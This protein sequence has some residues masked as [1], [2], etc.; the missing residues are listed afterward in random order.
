MHAGGEIARAYEQRRG[1]KWSGIW[2]LD[3]GLHEWVQ[4]GGGTY[5]YEQ[6]EAQ[7]RGGAKPP[8][9]QSVCVCGG[10]RASSGWGEHMVGQMMM[11]GAGPGSGQDNYRYNMEIQGDTYI[12]LLEGV[13]RESQ[14]L[15][16]SATF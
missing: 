2:I 4:R 10:V 9:A 8:W 14:D 7:P 12:Q 13:L 16:C 1:A 6:R 15:T 11:L 3:Q 5:R